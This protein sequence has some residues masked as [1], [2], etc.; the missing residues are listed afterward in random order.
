MNSAP[1]Q[2]KEAMMPF[3][4]DSFSV[5]FPK[6]LNKMMNMYHDSLD[7]ASFINFDYKLPISNYIINCVVI[8]KANFSKIIG[9]RMFIFPKKNYI[10]N[11]NNLHNIYI[12]IYILKSLTIWM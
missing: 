2:N 11:Q 7:L 6:N 3:D 5:F 12:Y 1:I 8:S 4:N 10:Q 9:K